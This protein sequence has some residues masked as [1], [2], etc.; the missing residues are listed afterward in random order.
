MFGLRMMG[1]KSKG[2]MTYIE[3][4]YDDEMPVSIVGKRMYFGYRSPV[5]LLPITV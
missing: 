4:D 5:G 3:G 1:L 2:G